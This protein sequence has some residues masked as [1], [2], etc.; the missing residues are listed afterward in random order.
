[1]QKNHLPAN[2]IYLFNVN[3]NTASFLHIVVCREDILHGN[4]HFEVELL[5]Q[6][7]PVHILQMPDSSYI[8][9]TGHSYSLHPS[10]FTLPPRTLDKTSCSLGSP[11]LSLPQ[12]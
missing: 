11:T 2:L 12:S 3:S 6:S 7:K 1:M 4:F 5:P 9:P 8:F 10:K